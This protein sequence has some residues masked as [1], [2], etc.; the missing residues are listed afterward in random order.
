[1]K[2]DKSGQ[3]CVVSWDDYI[4]MGQVHVSKDK[5]V[6]REEVIEI[7]KHL[8]G[9]AT[10]WVK[11]FAVGQDHKHVERIMNG[12]RTT[13]NNLA[14]MY[15]LFKDHKPGRKTRPIVTGITSNTRSLS[16][17]VANLMESV[18]NIDKSGFEVISGEDN[19]TKKEVSNEKSLKLKDLKYI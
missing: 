12:A 3:F 19:L 4:E 10:T 15:L 16:D 9:H 2:T 13:S 6:T 8:N 17:L 1:M 5:K 11:V 7:E 14:S 18:A